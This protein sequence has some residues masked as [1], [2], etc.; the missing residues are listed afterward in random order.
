MNTSFSHALRVV[1]CSECGAAM[2]VDL[3]GGQATC[4][5]C[6]ESR[7]LGPRVETVPGPSASLAEDERLAALSSADRRLPAVPEAVKA[8]TR[9]DGF[10]LRDEVF[11]EALAAWWGA[12]AAI[13]TGGEEGGEAAHV[14]FYHLTMLLYRH[15]KAHK[16]DLRMRG[17]LESAVEATRG[18]R[19]EQ[20]LRCVLAREAARA[21]DLAAA[22]DWLAP[23]DPRA[24]DLHA[25]G[26][27]RYTAAYLATRHGHFARVHPLLGAR[28][29]D[30]PLAA[31]LDVICAVLRA[32]AHERL[33]DLEAAVLELVE[34]MGR[35]PGGPA[36]IERSIRN[37]RD[38][39]LCRQS[40]VRARR[41]HDARVA[42]RAGVGRPPEARALLWGVPCLFFLGLAV[43]TDP[44]STWPGTQRLDT[45]FFVLAASF[46][47]PIV[48]LWLR[49]RRVASTG[50]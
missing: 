15:L 45:L 22:E 47:V 29:G 8:L 40:F 43:M 9:D 11:D 10:S 33:G 23:C 30:V 5:A 46:A 21:G 37:T 49:R 7:E 42:A 6:G 18:H 26:A 31:N 19:D 25:D 39:V 16:D 3:A 12:L 36:E 4:G 17:L 41:G 32:N 50:R 38:V 13:D 27:F 14:R 34:V 35:A 44:S 24:R 28:S 20:I 1:L 48:V 2:H